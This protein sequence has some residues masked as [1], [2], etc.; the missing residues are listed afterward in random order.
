MAATVMSGGAEAINF[1]G[2]SFKAR[3][4]FFHGTHRTVAPDE[5]LERLRPYSS[6]VGITRLADITGLDRI[7]VP[8][9]L[10]QR[11]NAPTLANAAGKGYTLA[12]AAASASM[13]ALEVYHA[14]NVRL[15]TL[16]TSYQRLSESYPVPSL[17]DLP[18]TKRS[19]FRPHRPERWLLGW[20]V[21]GQREVPVPYMSA[22]LVPFPD[23]TPSRWMPFEMGSNGLA[24]GNHFLEAITSALYEVLERDAVACSQVAART[25]GYQMPRVKLETVSSPP[26][27]YLL[28]R[29]DW[30][31]MKAVLLDSTVDTAVPCY[32]AILAD[33]RAAQ[34]GLFR[35]YGAHLDP[36]VAMVR[37]LTE[38][39]Q[40]RLIAI[41]GSRDDY[42]RRDQL[43]N[44]IAGNKSGLDVFTSLPETVDATDLPSEATETFE[45]DLAL[46][47]RKA[48]RAGIGQIVVLDLSHDEIGVP[49]V[50]VVVPGLE[51]Y[52]F[53]YYRPGPR[54]LA[55]A[56]SH[57]TTL[58]P[59]TS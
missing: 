22:S 38:A 12:A 11:P 49:V 45:G 3:K 31:G 50:R 5:T 4:S 1:R 43:L 46:L 35:G 18:L 19:L 56:A 52:M 36:T 2:Q 10:A 54:A 44:R 21:L 34:A 13:E 26:V 7:G 14:E 58:Q 8:T 41:A 37:A 48:R 47:M 32:I 15:R 53:D 16:C 20:D 24:G 51:G 28:D 27:A 42:F 40:S 9:V 30:A 23:Q 59:T 29:L 57:A 55:F 6:T 17:E 39:T 33:A 25:V